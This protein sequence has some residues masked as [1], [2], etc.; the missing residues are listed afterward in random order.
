MNIIGFPIMGNL[1]SK[2][3]HK[4][5]TTPYRGPVNGIQIRIAITSNSDLG[6]STR[7]I[8]IKLPWVPGKLWV[9]INRPFVPLKLCPKRLARKVPFIFDLTA[10]TIRK[11]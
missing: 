11:S 6:R 10:S 7:T 8:L 1:R 3:K 2:E 4:S 9:I 5:K